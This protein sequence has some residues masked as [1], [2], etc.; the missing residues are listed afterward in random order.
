MGYKYTASWRRGDH[1]LKFGVEHTRNLDVNYHWVPAYGSGGDTF[2]GFSSGQI[3]RDVDGSIAGATFGEGWA[4]FMLGL[5]SGVSGNV[6]GKAENTGHFNQ[7]H[8]NW[9]VQ[10]DWKVGPN[11][12]AYLGL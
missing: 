2:D 4:D 6:L 10:D 5:P 3:I 8:Y 12:T 1:Y 7:S 11:L 9:F